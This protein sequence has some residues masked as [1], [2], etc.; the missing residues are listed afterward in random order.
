MNNFHKLRRIFAISGTHYPDDTFCQ[1]HVN[2]VLIS[3]VTGLPIHLSTAHRQTKIGVNIPQ[4]RCCRCANFQ[5]KKS[6]S[7]FGLHSSVRTAA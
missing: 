6:G 7:E 5:L 3:I 2:K 1:K 4:G